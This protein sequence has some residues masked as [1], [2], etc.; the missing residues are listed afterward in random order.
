MI[1]TRAQR[2]ALNRIHGRICQDYL[3]NN[4]EM[5]Y[6]CLPT[7]RDI[8][9]TVQP[10]PGCVMVPFAGMWLGIESDGYTHS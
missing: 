8:R 3:S 7:Y 9:R 2:E 10:G 6:E 4:P 5:P 1:L